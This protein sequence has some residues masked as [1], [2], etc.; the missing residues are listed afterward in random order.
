MSFSVLNSL[1]DVSHFSFSA[2]VSVSNNCNPVLPSQFFINAV[3]CISTQYL[4]LT[5]CSV[6]CLIEDNTDV[7]LYVYLLLWVNECHL[8]YVHVLKY[9]EVVHSTWPYTWLIGYTRY[10]R[11]SMLVDECIPYTIIYNCSIPLLTKNKKLWQNKLTK[12]KITVNSQYWWYQMSKKSYHTLCHSSWANK[13]SG[14]ING[15][16]T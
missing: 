7:W 8:K 11:L 2:W 12:T 15:G 5:P 4:L 10:N 6:P 14:A 16:L 13:Q 3:L 9:L 1:L